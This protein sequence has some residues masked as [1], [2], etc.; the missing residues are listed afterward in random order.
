VFFTSNASA[1]NENPRRPSR[2]RRSSRGALSHDISLGPGFLLNDDV[3]EAR[4]AWV[5]FHVQR[6]NGLDPW[7][8]RR[9]IN[10]QRPTIV[11]PAACRGPHIEHERKM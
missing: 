7:I 9:R 2:S 5:L 11:A 1:E 4:L 6:I 10:R 8:E 3:I